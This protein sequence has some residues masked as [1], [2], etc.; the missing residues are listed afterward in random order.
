MD[1]TIY[2]I[3]LFVKVTSDLWKLIHVRSAEEHDED[4]RRK[5]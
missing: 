2:K 4:K 3:G 5:G 1:C